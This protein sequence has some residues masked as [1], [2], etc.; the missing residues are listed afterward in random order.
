MAELWK[1]S[2]WQ[3]SRMIASRRV[4]PSEVMAA[5]LKRIEEVNP[6]LNAF[7]TLVPDSAMAEARAAD[8]KVTRTKSLGPLF[9]VPVSIK[10]LIFTKGLRT[11]FG[12]RMYENFIPDQNEIVVERLKAAGAILL[13]KTTTCEFGY[14]AVT[15]SPLWGITRNPWNLEMTPAGSSGG[16]AA[17]VA[18]GLGPMAVGSDGGGSIRAPASYCGIFGLKP[19]RGRVPVYPLLAGWETLDRRLVHVGPLTRTVADAAL[20]MEVIAG[21]DDRDPVTLPEGRMA[22]RRELKKGV[23]GLKVAWSLDLGYVVVDEG[24]EAAV[25]SGIKAF[26]SLG[27]KLEEAGPDVPP[28]HDAFQLIFGAGCAAA[29]GDRLEEWGD[30]LDQGLVKLT[31]IGLKAGAADYIRATNRRHTLWEKMQAFFEKYDLLLTPTLPVPPFPV[32]TDWPREIAGEKV[33]PLNYLAFTYP[34]NLTGQ[35]AA[36]VP[37]GWTADGLPLGLQIVGRRFEDA[38][39]LRAAAAFEKA[40]PWAERW[41]DL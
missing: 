34:F 14:K 26:A 30:R 20:M 31:Q 19:S 39:V 21:R 33:H 27:V 10:D 23:R 5:V 11:T 41:P 36:S 25:N 24:V 1:M 3:L 35:P 17:A 9:G 40:R 6:K 32:G 12:S 28:M 38:T 29:I 2:G 4:K 22:F 18:S 16:A 37:C 13:G 7:C 8:K 15:D